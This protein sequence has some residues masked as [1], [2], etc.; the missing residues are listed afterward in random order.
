MVGRSLLHPERLAADRPFELAER[1]EG[2]TSSEFRSAWQVRL[3]AS[4]AALDGEFGFGLALGDEPGLTPFGDPLDQAWRGS[5]P[6]DF[7]LPTSMPTET[8]LNFAS[9]P[10][11]WLA[12]RSAERAGF[13]GVLSWMAAKTREVAPDAPIGLLGLGDEDA[14]RGLDLAR[15]ASTFDFVETYPGGLATAQVRTQLAPDEPVPD[16]W[17]T[18]FATHA[19]PADLTH[20]VLAHVL[21]GARALVLWSDRALV[22][23]PDRLEA[24][25]QGASRAR[26]WLESYPDFPGAPR[27][28]AILRDFDS[29]AA[30]FHSLARR[31]GG[32]WRALLGGWRRQHAPRQRAEDGL[33][34][35]LEDL[36]LT[37][38]VVQANAYQPRASS[39]FPVWIAIH[40]RVLSQATER[41]LRAHLAAGGRLWLAGRC[42]VQ[43]SEGRALQPDL[44]RELTEQH[45]GRVRRL[46]L[47]L[48]AY[49][50]ERM[51][52]RSPRAAG[53]RLLVR[54]WLAQTPVELAPFE[55]RAEDDGAPFLRRWSERPDG[56]R[57]CVA[58]EHRP[59]SGEQPLP[60]LRPR[61]VRVFGPDPAQ[62]IW[63]SGKTAGSNLE[64]H[65]EPGEPAVFRWVRARP[66]PPVRR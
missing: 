60:A 24:L 5:M 17:R 26:A 4:I 45:P 65:L 36:G 6:G 39:T 27:G 10:A 13:T 44:E 38:G 30:G 19:E 43:D 22:G 59:V 23:R 52:G 20:Q 1:L 63:C 15:I 31:Q 42:F 51:A 2:L 55:I 57:L 35:L 66:A 29:V 34:Y 11:E 64:R 47:D 3:R 40:H 16:L 61:T 14:Y 12:T 58:L 32:D 54:D 62:V 37:P 21:D 53:A 41:G 18:V 8:A 48:G 56:E 7:R 50:S 9:A 46:S 25:G 28:V 33:R 49:L